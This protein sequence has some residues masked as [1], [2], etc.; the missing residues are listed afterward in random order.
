MS[1]C[2]TPLSLT[3]EEA[4]VWLEDTTAFEYVRE[5]FQL[6][7][8][9]RRGPAFDFHRS[10]RIVGYAVLRAAAR[11]NS[12]IPHLFLRRV[13][14]VKPHDRSEDPTGCY[15][16]DV[17]AE[18]IDPRTVRPGVPGELTDRAR[19]LPKPCAHKPADAT[20]RRTTARKET[21]R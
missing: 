7:G 6:C 15:A 1:L 10:G 12:G 3:A 18:A 11:N 4:I 16:A 19:G 17:P 8:T 21:P 5:H 20:G 9:R 13:F 2:L 14:W